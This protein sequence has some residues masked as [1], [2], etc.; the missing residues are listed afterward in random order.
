MKDARDS[1]VILMELWKL[2]VMLER[3]PIDYLGA[4]L[5]LEQVSQIQVAPSGLYNH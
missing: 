4:Y 3:V 1:L 5:G 2:I